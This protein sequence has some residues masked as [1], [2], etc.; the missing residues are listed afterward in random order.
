MKTLFTILIIIPFILSGQQLS[1]KGRFSVDFPVGC[2]PAT[3]RI[4]QNVSKDQNT[5]YDYGVLQSTTKDTI[6]TYTSS[7][8]YE[9]VQLLNPSISNPNASKY[10]TLSFEVYNSPTPEFS[11][12]ACAKQTLKVEIED[13]NYDQY[14]IF[15][16]QTDSIDIDPL[17]SAS[18]SYTTNSAIVTV[19][20]LYLDSFNDHCG[21][22]SQMIDFP[23]SLYAPSVNTAFF[24]EDCNGKYNL[25]IF[26]SVL[27]DT[28]TR[29][30]L[31][32]GN[33]S[34]IIYEGR[35]K[36]KEV[37]GDI[38]L[39]NELEKCLKISAIDVCCAT[40]V[41]NQD[42]CISFNRKSS[43]YFQKSY[44]SYV[45]EGTRIA[46]QTPFQDSILIRRNTH[47]TD[48]YQYL[49]ET[50]PPS[51]DHPTASRHNQEVYELSAISSGCNGTSDE[52]FLSGPF[53]K[54]SSKSSHTN[55]VTIAL[56]EPINQLI[57][58]PLKELI[59]YSLDSSIVSLIPFV[60]ETKLPPK[61]G[62]FQM[63]CARYT[64]QSGEIIYSNRIFT[65]INYSV[66]VPSAFTPNQDGLN[67][68]L[69]I[70]G[71]PTDTGSIQVYNRWGEL[72]FESND[73]LAG[74]DGR[75]RNS[76]APEGT[77]RYKVSFEIPEGGIRTQVGTFV[78]I[79]K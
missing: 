77:Y 14:R 1:K 9:I 41:S 70:F 76:S 60:E 68:V 50:L 12:Y 58:T 27:S 15:F 47:T 64:Y 65:K 37:F 69:N 42:Y 73:I 74:W 20:G 51:Y 31:D 22:L 56:T 3:V 40:S 29:I 75:I 17:A 61:I 62:E 23:S 32:D 43:Q 18:H 36:S 4:T 2:V 55:E 28:K 24:Q 10:D 78:L 30:E 5:T 72:I 33:N 16:T 46:F 13:V 53:I 44:V 7:G 35:I 45:D 52:L 8:Q 34:S 49:A 71:L 63:I 48:S 38:M 66:F 25:N 19:K 57:G 59:F 21:E 39:S 11:V 6:F 67:D 79:R 54:F 26:F